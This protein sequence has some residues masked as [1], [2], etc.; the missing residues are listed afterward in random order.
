MEACKNKFVPKYL[1]K[2][3]NLEEK[4][5][6]NLIKH[7]DNDLQKDHFKSNDKEVVKEKQTL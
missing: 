2:I 3:S 5:F 1:L 6:L 4:S 7:I